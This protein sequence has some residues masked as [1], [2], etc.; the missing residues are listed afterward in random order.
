MRC[1]IIMGGIFDWPA[2]KMTKGQPLRKV[3]LGTFFHGLTCNLTLSHFLGRTSQKTTL[4]LYQPCHCSCLS[5]KTAVL[6]AANEIRERF[7]LQA[8]FWSDY[9]VSN[10]I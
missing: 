3:T 7:P 9:V 10:L 5:V 2:L 8:D 1:T 6:K 4:Y